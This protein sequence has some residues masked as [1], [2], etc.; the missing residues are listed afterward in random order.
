[1]KTLAQKSGFIYAILWPIVWVT[2]GLFIQSC[3]DD[4][5]TPEP[6]ETELEQLKQAVDRFKDIEVAQAEGYEV[7]VTGYRTGMGHHFLKATI[8]DDTF[9]V[10]KPEVLLYIPD[11][12]GGWEFVAV[13]YGIP[14]PDLNNPPAA[15][16]GFTGDKDVWEISEE[17]SLWTLHA[18]VIMDNPA[19]VF[20][21]MNSKLP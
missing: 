18:W 21:P 3:N 11:N 19:G 8:L 5:P 20:A 1:M 9:E 15:P 4:D 16:E 6:F 13:E 14:I 2:L 10:T 12:N 17:F 7:D